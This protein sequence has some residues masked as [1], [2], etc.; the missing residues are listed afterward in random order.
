MS[1]A[2]LLSILWLSKKL[3]TLRAESL[4]LGGMDTLPDNDG[5]YP[6]AMSFLSSKTSELD[7]SLLKSLIESG[8]S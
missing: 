7:P 6:K 1:H 8:H 4:C 5:F 2:Y 3:S